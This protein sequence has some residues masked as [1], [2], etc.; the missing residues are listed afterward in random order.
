MKVIDLLNI[1]RK[2]SAVYYKRYF[3]AVAVIELPA[4]T[5]EEPL[6]FTIE[7]SP[8]NQKTITANF[9]EPLDYPL[10]PILNEV[11]ALVR[12]K[13]ESGALPL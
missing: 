11:K 7:T 13:D 5:I 9:F 2:D 4:K 10:V 6:E 12:A 3:T 1:V 8:L